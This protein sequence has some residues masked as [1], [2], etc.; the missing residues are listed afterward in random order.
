M[1]LNYSGCILYTP[2]GLFQQL[3]VAG[4]K[5]NLG[6]GTDFSGQAPLQETRAETVLEPGGYSQATCLIWSPEKISSGLKTSMCCTGTV[7]PCA[8]R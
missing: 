6:P 5:G 1:N 7:C 2:S 4:I 8:P 3:E